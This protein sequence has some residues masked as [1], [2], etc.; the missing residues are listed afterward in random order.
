MIEEFFLELDQLWKLETAQK[1]E[2]QLIGSTALFF[3]MNPWRGT[4]DTD[5]LKI[6]TFTQA[7]LAHI[8]KI[9]G[10]GSRLASRH[11][12]YL[13]LVDKAFPFLPQKPLFHPVEH[14]NVRLQNFS[15]SALD[16]TDLVV[17]KLK[18]FRAQDVGDIREVAATGVLQNDKF[19]ERFKSALQRWSM[20]SR[21][22][23]FPQCVKNLHTIQRDFLNV[24]EAEIE[25]PRWIGEF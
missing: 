1:L 21:A 11:Q 16:I 17:S 2:L 20:D 5:A 25:L 4:K 18:P 12:L 23:D 8:E 24:P 6:E 15:V 10:K 22:E 9:A 13:E 7:E 14:L 19:V 3:Q